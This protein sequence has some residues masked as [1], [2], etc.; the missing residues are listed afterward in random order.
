[1]SLTNELTNEQSEA[2]SHAGQDMVLVAAAGSGKTFVLTEIFA[3]LVQEQGL[4]PKEIVAITFTEK[5]AGELKGRIAQRIGSARSELDDAPIGTIHSFAANRLREAATELPRDFVIWEENRS[6]L[7]RSRIVH[8]ELRYRLHHPT[9]SLAKLI[10]EYGWRPVS[11]LLT[12]QL[13]MR[14]QLPRLVEL[15]RDPLWLAFRA[16]YEQDEVAYTRHKPLHDALD[17]EDLEEAAL[18][19]LGDER[20]R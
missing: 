18:R 20:L 19:L 2:L 3:H 12:V 14:W 11:R 4:A 9:E 8:Q 7:E 5:A 13:G 17:F 6:Q 10:S 1:M 16:L 15:S